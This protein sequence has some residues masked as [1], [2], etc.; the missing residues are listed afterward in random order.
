MLFTKTLY[1]IYLSAGFT[2][3]FGHCIGMCGPIVVSLTLN[4]KDKRIYLPHILYNSGRIITY[5]VLGGITGAAGSLTMVIANIAGLQKAVMIF[6]GT[7]IVFMGLAMSGWLPFGRIFRDQNAPIGIISK[8]F[9]KLSKLHSTSIYFPLGL[10]LGLLPCG[11]VYTALIGVA[12]AGMEAESVFESVF[13]GIVLMLGFGI[14]TVPALILVAKL[15]D[16]GWLKSKEIIYKFSSLL[17]IL[18]GGYFIYK[19]MRY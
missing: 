12:R 16:L 7:L 15:T 5:S 11:P 13:L 4:L 19:A 8:G 14:G 6:T 3:G 1:L 9:S 18:V 17:M 10:L 2:V